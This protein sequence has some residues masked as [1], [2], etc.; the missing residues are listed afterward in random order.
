MDTTDTATNTPIQRA[1][2]HFDGSPTKMAKALCVPGG[3]AV[4]RQSVE[5]WLR[6]NAVPPEFVRPIHDMTGIPAWEFRPT[7]WWVIWPDL[8]DAPDAPAIPS[9]EQEPA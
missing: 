2:A 5:H 3:R 4:L 7:D 9:S 6:Q 1:L 8:K